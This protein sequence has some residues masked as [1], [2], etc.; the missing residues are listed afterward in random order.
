MEWPNMVH[1]SEVQSR[2]IGDGVPV[3]RA[4]SVTSALATVPIGGKYRI[5]RA[6]GDLYLYKTASPGYFA[7]ATE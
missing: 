7:V 6:Q 2:L 4:M 3:E 5:E 1:A